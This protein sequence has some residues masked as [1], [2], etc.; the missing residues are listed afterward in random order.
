MNKLIFFTIF[1]LFSSHGMT[2]NLSST[3]NK[4]VKMSIKSVKDY[5]NYR[6]DQLTVLRNQGLN[7]IAYTQELE[8]LQNITQLPASDITKQLDTNMEDMR[9]FDGLE[10]IRDF[11]N[12][13]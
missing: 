6:L 5:K 11:K 8:R 2:L 9:S 13:R 3:Y 12:M 10:I 7:D 4:D 1:V